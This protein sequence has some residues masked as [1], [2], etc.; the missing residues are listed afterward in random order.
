MAR[1]PFYTIR[2]FPSREA[3]FFSRPRPEWP[4]EKSIY[5]FAVL[6]TGPQKIQVTQLKLS[7]QHG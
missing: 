2:A 6:Y 4:I 1:A 7:Y 3:H 5:A